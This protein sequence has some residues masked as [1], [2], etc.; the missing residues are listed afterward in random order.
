MQKKVSSQNFLGPLSDLKNF[1]GP[2][3]DVKIMGQP[4]RK[5]YHL[6]FP[7]KFVIINPLGGLKHLRASLFASD[8]PTSV[9]EW[10][11]TC[12]IKIH[13]QSTMIYSFYINYYHCLL[14]SVTTSTINILFHPLP[15]S[16]WL[17]RALRR[18]VRV[19]GSSMDS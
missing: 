15:T 11:L 8:P 12:Y 9:C 14:Y 3:F 10:S 19:L 17:G 6:N 13:I 4:H 1:R 7:G 18:Q 5:S 2:F 16:S